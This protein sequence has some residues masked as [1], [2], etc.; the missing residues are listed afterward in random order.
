MPR[1]APLIFLEKDAFK[2][3]IDKYMQKALSKGVPPLFK[4]L[5]YL[6][7]DVAKIKIIESIKFSDIIRYIAVVESR[8]AYYVD[9]LDTKSFVGALV[10]RLEQFNHS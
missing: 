10:P 1:K 2:Q 7:K 6:Y 5:K 4:E 9:L 3:A 8:N